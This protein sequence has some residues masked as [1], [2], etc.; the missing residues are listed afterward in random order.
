MDYVL[1]YESVAR[2][3]TTHD[4]WSSGVDGVAEGELRLSNSVLAVLG[5]GLEGLFSSTYID[6]HGARVAT[7]PSVSLLVG[8]GV[9][10]RY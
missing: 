7:L 1:A 2:S 10:L 5:L 6:V 8:A 9:R 4:R 3:S